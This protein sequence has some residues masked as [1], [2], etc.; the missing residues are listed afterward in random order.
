[1]HNV[2]IDMQNISQILQYYSTVVISDLSN[3]VGTI[4]G[5]R[6]FKSPRSRKESFVPQ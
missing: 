5:R 3:I 6:S 2:C 1:M 4:F